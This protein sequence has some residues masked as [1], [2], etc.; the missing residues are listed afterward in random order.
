ML[1]FNHS[2][3]DLVKKAF[4]D[5]LSLNRDGKTEEEYDDQIERL[6][7]ILKELHEYADLSEIKPCKCGSATWVDLEIEANNI[8]SI[9]CLR[10]HKI[11]RMFMKEDIIDD[12]NNSDI[13]C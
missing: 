6:N 7:K 13:R 1:K 4:E 9:G 11:T 2:D 10:G 5:F 3:L 8:W 12:W